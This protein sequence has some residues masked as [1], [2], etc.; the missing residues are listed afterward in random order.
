MQ[1]FVFLPLRGGAVLHMCEIVIICVHFTPPPPPPPLS[2]P[3]YVFIPCAPVE[4]APCFTAQKTC[5]RDSCV[6]LGCEQK[7]LIFSMHAA[8]KAEL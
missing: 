7:K 8:I 2:R 4:I 6:L 3:R 5:F 1:T